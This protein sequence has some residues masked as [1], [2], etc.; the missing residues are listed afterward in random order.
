MSP[1]KKTL[2][3]G[4]AI[5]FAIVGT[6]GLLG[7][8]IFKNKKEEDE[9]SGGG[10]R[11]EGGRSIIIGDSQTPYI[12]KQS[13]KIEMLGETGGENVL[14]KGG[15]GLSWLKGAVEK[16]PI[17]K[18]VSNVVIN[19]G[20]NGSFNKSDNIEGLVSS[21]RR[22]FPNANLLAVQGSWGWSNYNKDVTLQKV[23]AYYDRF[24]KLGV[25]VINPPIGAIEPHGDKPVYKLIGAN[26]DKEIK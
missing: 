12:K 7:F 6:I 8:V 18:D 21:L 14:W 3:K 20:T 5:G 22:V 4:L 17:T 23:T 2:L 13:K 25:T 15:M 10:G 11:I 26:I 1:N 19:I 9:D 16:Y 24:N